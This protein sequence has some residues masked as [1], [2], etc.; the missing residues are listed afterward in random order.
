MVAFAS[1]DPRVPGFWDERFE[2][3]FTPWDRGGVPAALRAF[4]ADAKQPLRTLVPG[5]GTGYE[6]AFLADAG[7]DATAIDF[8]PAA[9]NAAKA[10]VGPWAERVLQADFFA[11]QPQRPPELVYERAFLCAMPPALWNDVARRWADLLPSGALLAGFFFFDDAP[12]GPP[13]GIDRER[14][15]QLL[16]PAF[17]C[18][19]DE[20]VADSIAVFEGKERWMVWQ[21][22]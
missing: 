6:L 19:Q 16:E 1:R 18:I 9:V 21:R 20:A 10:A 15:A 4:V 14:L 5:C 8:S 7:W 13:F 17:A 3:G 2:R 11:Y 12:K 22:R